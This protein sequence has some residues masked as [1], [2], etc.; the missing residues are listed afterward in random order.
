MDD[1]SRVEELQASLQRSIHYN[2]AS[3]DDFG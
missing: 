2:R 1:A 3:N